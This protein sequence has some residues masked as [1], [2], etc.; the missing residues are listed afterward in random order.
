MNNVLN[1]IEWDMPLPLLENRNSLP[2]F[3]VD[4]F[5][6]PIGEYINALAENTQTSKDMAAVIALGILAVAAGRCY[7]IEGNA[8]YYEPLNLYVLL[9]AEPGE[10]K[11]CDSN[12]YAP[13]GGIKGIQRNVA[14][15]FTECKV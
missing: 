15:H 5:P 9:V 4:S 11:S 13:S 10:R 1:N 14:P 12:I 7:C 2:S 6:S 8:N 3:P